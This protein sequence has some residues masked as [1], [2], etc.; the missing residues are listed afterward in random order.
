MKFEGFEITW[1]E[2]H[3]SAQ[4][5]SL[6]DTPNVRLRVEQWFA[7]HRLEGQ[8]AWVASWLDP[9]LEV[10]TI[11]EAP[12]EQPALVAED[13]QRRRHLVELAIEASRNPPPVAPGPFAVPGPTPLDADEWADHHDLQ[14]LSWEEAFGEFVTAC[15]DT[16]DAGEL[17]RYRSLTQAL[18]W[19]YAL[20]SSLKIIWGRMLSEEIREKASKATDERARRSAERNE[21]ALPKFNLNTDYA[22]SGYVQ[23]LS[24]RRPYS[25]WGEVMLA[26]VFQSQFFLAIGWVRGQLIH[27]ATAP[28]L[29]LRQPRPG[30]APRWKWRASEK[31]AR[32][33]SS[34]PGRAAYDYLL[35]EHD[36]IGLLGH[37]T[38]VFYEAGQYLRQLLRSGE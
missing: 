28:P 15:Q 16:S 13:D 1:A 34:D 19:A 26:G 11:N 32:G 25:H 3:L 14:L 36:V 21:A 17:R 37:L 7:D 38:E 23:R 33:R 29:E 9:V 35:V 22:F 27:A 30:V 2:D 4:L 8:L 20:D 10:P 24:D 6:G 5:R 12:I 18:D 31:F